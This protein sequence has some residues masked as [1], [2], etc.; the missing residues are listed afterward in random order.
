MCEFVC[1]ITNPSARVGR[2]TGSISKQSLTSLNTE[3]S[4][5]LTGCDTKVKE[6]WLSYYLP[7]AGWRIVR[8]IPFP[9]IL[10]IYIN[11]YMKN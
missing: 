3:L 6:P 8:F 1:V 9:K 4:F 10:M 7:I 5:S 2:D 11:I